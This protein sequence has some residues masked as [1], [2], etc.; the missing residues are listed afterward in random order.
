MMHTY[1]PTIPQLVRDYP[2]NTH[3][4]FFIPSGEFVGL[5][6]DESVAPDVR[7]FFEDIISK[8]SVFM[9]QQGTPTVS[10]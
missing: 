10:K 1:F 8:L 4:L 3:G 6:F 5:M 9:A 2:L 7:H